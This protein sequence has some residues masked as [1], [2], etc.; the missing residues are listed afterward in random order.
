M[1]LEKVDTTNATIATECPVRGELAPLASSLDA[2]FLRAGT[3]LA[4]AV[5]M[6]GRVIGGL[7][8][9]AAALDEKTAG[10][11][12]ADLRH[13]AQELMALPIRQSERAERMASVVSIA[14]ALNEHVMQMYRALRFLNI[15]S[16]N[17]KIAAPGED[18][19]VGFVEDMTI[20]LNSAE[21]QLNGFLA[22]LKTLTASVAEVRQADRSLAA[23]G[24]KVVSVVPAQLAKDAGELSGYLAKVAT[25]AGKVAVIARSVQ[26]KVAVVLGAL[27]VGDSTRQRLE[28]VVTALDLVDAHFEDGVPDPAVCGHVDRL[29]SAQLAATADDFGREAGAMLKSLSDLTPDIDM[30]RELIVEQDDGGGGVFLTRLDQGVSDVERVTGTLRD[31]NRRSEAMVGVI[32]D[33]AA[34]LSARLVN[35]RKIR[36]NVQVIATNT[37]VL[38]WRMGPQGKAVSVIAAEVDGCASRLAA[39]TGSVA[40]TIGD[41][42]CIETELRGNA[43]GDDDGRRDMGET[44]AG[45]LTII[46]QACQRTEQ[47][48]MEGGDDV[49]NLADMLIQ[50]GNQLQAELAIVA[51]LRAMAETLEHRLPEAEPDDAAT[52]SLTVLLPR[53]ASLYTMAQERTVHARF[54]LPSMIA[55]AATANVVEEEE[56]DDGLF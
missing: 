37:G 16:M 20:K 17:I 40:E 2:R 52:E 27:Q 53:I 49:R 39:I 11:A 25:L 34:A 3:T 38:S 41:L 6:I 4:N 30:L 15:Y 43:T 54:L 50:T 1:F 33:T 32:A 26:G 29:L 46:R 31:A 5:E 19:F 9:V 36:A 23:E 55:A 18:Q 56:D 7:D 28:H 22:Q 14:H 47:V 10:V 24:A 51:V 44:L 45:A 13:V 42:T 8:G 21:Q 35:I 48:N 12:V